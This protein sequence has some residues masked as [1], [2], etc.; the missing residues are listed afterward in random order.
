MRHMATCF[1]GQRIRHKGE[2]KQ[3]RRKVGKTQHRTD[4]DVKIRLR[5][6]KS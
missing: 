3:N 4:V 6:Q 5:K 2:D 1:S